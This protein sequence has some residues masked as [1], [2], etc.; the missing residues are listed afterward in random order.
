[1]PKENLFAQALAAAR[2]VTSVAAGDRATDV[3]AAGAHGIRSI[4]V[5]W[6]FGSADELERAGAAALASHPL[7]LSVL[8]A[9]PD[10]ASP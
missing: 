5:T 10:G 8:L 4:G 7:E 9:P 6:G 3:E 1:M 2:P